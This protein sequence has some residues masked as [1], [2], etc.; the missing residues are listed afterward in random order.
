ML[1]QSLE[2]TPGLDLLRFSWK[3]AFVETYDVIH[4]HWPEALLDGSTWFRRR[5]KELAFALLLLRIRLKRIAVVR[6]VHNLDLPQGLSFVRKQLITKC[7]DMTT[8]QISINPTT[9]HKPDLPQRL[10]PHGHYR[11]WFADVPRSEQV[12][13]RIAFTGLIRRY[14]G[15]EN[16][17]DCF[18]HT[19]GGHPDLSLSVTGKPSSQDLENVVRNAAATDNRIRFS[20]GYV[21]EESLVAAITE[22]ELV[23]LPYQHMHNSGS[24]L[25][26][27]SVQR[28]VLIPR[29][30]TNEL[31]SLEVGA[32]WVYLY[33]GQLSA[34][35]LTSTLADL[36][37]RTPTKAPDL[38][39]RG[40]GTAGVQHRYAFREAQLIKTQK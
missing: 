3:T 37:R 29:N 18:M 39:A 9:P 19:A 40:W 33:E 32:G 28:P 6:T 10:I 7:D 25:A 36:R 13:G 21:A 22:A 12:R 20:F 34:Q 8:L 5:G 26:A 27:L 35:D 1:G 4:F 15:V 23:V 30:E 31:L 2:T 14:K 38:S 17:L 24:A 11:D 16:L